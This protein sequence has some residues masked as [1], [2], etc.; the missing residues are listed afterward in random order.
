MQY[1]MIGT[2][3]HVDHGKTQLIKA[4]T[5]IDADRLKEEKKRGIT[6]E[7]GFAYFALPDGSR[8]GIIDV[9]GHERF[10]RNMLSGAGGIDF[11]LFVVAANEGVMPQTLEHLDILN[12]LNIKQGIV[13]V[14]KK[15]TV[16]PDFLE[17][18]EEEIKEVVQGTFLEQAPLLSV[19]AHTGEGIEELKQ[20]IVC[21]IGQVQEKNLKCP[22]RLPVDRAFS[23]TG[24]G[25]VVTGTLIEGKLEV[26]EEVMLYPQ[27]ERIK[28]RKLQVHSQEVL[29]AYA[30]QRVAINLANKKKEDIQRGTIIALADSMQL[31]Y[32]A[33]VKISVLK[34]SKWAVKHGSRVHIH[35]ASRTLLGKLILF[36]REEILPGE[37]AYAQIRLEEPTVL[38]KGD[39]M[40]L[41]FYS[42][43]ETIGGA[44]VLD[45]FPKKKKHS[46]KTVVRAFEIREFGTRKEELELAIQEA[47][48]SFQSIEELCGYKSFSRKEIGQDLNQLVQEKKIIRLSSEFY[49]LAEEEEKLCKRL[50]GML[51]DFHKEY[52]LKQGMP[53]EEVRSRLVQ[54][55]NTEAAELCV[56]YFIQEKK[57][58]DTDGMIHLTDF[59]IKHQSEQKVVL[60]E[61]I[62]RYKTA[63]FSPLATS[64]ITT[65]YKEV[66]QFSQLLLG[67]VREEKLVLLDEQYCIHPDYYKKAI[68]I[69]LE[70]GKEGKLV[71]L[72]EY[73][74]ALAS[75]RKLSLCLLEHFDKK[76]LT[77][78][79]GE[80]RVVRKFL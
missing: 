65:E 16:E 10:I 30:G 5:G 29:E 14:T 55:K 34:R 11:V 76:G 40:I 75:S 57:V 15:D 41:R 36:D 56:L 4:L 18:V 38:K 26:G 6:I 17:L 53:L 60:E 9:P 51:K 28:V 24:F 21:T 61:L 63:G 50:L 1:V 25:T 80:G 66:K 74:D 44:M 39:R 22:F 23:M 12:L 52:P 37:S 13:V 68:E 42:P 69:L 72:N 59:K 54:R 49:L 79:S 32:M 20:K 48:G 19:S 8:A 70:L 2:A 73:R 7:L 31:T 47:V 78:K 77:K 3:G 27:E 33:D 67:L 46:E 64:V 45:A 43:V 58:K 71:L 35:H 62:N